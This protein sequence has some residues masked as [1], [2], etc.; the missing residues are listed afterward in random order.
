MAKL[1]PRGVHIRATLRGKLF[2]ESILSPANPTPKC[3]GQI[4]APRDLWAQS[5]RPRVAQ[6]APSLV[7]SLRAQGEALARYLVLLVPHRLFV[8][9]RRRQAILAAW[10]RFQLI[11][12]ISLL[13]ASPPH[14]A[15][16]LQPVAQSRR[17]PFVPPRRLRSTFCFPRT[18]SSRRSPR[19]PVMSTCCALVA[20]V[21]SRRHPPVRLA[22][23]LLTPGAHRAISEPTTTTS[24]RKRRG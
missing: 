18:P 15:R 1:E 10:H 3:L 4:K 23:P 9:I 5:Q 22:L 6:L 19:L 7:L 20:H 11:Y 14:L 12:A 24:G 17:F 13:L 21:R 16:A 8:N 2:F